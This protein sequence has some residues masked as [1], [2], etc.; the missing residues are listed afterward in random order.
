MG[1]YSVAVVAS[2]Y[3]VAVPSTF[4]RAGPGA[5]AAFGMGSLVSTSLFRREI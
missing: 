1:H 2:V 3:V 5:R 4:R